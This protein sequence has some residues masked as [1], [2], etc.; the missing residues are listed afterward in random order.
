[1]AN[2]TASHNDM[3]V[4]Y[5]EEACSQSFLECWSCFFDFDL[6]SL[7][8]TH[9]EAPLVLALIVDVEARADLYTD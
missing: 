1:M 4:E 6:P 3:H 7:D 5:I 8:K 2:T 9:A